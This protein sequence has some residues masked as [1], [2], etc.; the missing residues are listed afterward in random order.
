MSWILITLL[1]AVFF[2]LSQALRKKALAFES[3]FDFI[4]SYA[5]VQF[6]FSIP[7][8][9]FDIQFEIPGKILVLIIIFCIMNIITAFFMYASYKNEEVSTV[10]PLI[11][12]SPAF[13]LVLSFFLLS[14]AP[15]TL[16]I[17][18]VVVI[19]IGGYYLTIKN[20]KNWH[21]PF[22]EIKKKYLFFMLL[23]LILASFM[24]IIDKTVLQTI[25]A[26]T[27]YFWAVLINTVFI[28]ILVVVSGR[29]KTV[30]KVLKEHFWIFSIPA[31]L[32]N[33]AAFSILWVIALPTVLVSLVIPIR[34]F[35]TLI[36]V[37]LGGKMYH[38]HRIPHKII[39][40]AI[41]LAGIFIIA[42]A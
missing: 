18:G 9:F 32:D 20:I 12:F 31:I 3:I 37:F 11:N 23:V 38:E 6:I 27:K 17:M 7:I 30:L 34:R 1:S 19:I 39:A 35:S 4:G 26:F 10:A 8:L 29:L 33:F 24:A 40:S 41:M 2:G 36:T 13:L 25:S 28:M 42:F 16:Q 14:E 5:I 15:T 22:T 21:H